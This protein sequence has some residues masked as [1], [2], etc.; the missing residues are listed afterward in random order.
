M[1]EEKNIRAAGEKVASRRPVGDAS[2]DA[3]AK[4]NG[5]VAR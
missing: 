1:N 5:T 2:T 3:A 4:E